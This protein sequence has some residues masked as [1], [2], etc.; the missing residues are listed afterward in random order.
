VAKPHLW[1]KF[2]EESIRLYSLV[3]Q[4]GRMVSRNTEILG[5]PMNKGDMVWLGLAQANRDPRKFADPDA[6][7]MERADLNHHLGFGAGVHR[8]IGMHLA[9]AELV[10]ALRAW[11]AVI[12]E[13]RLAEG[14]VITERGGQLRLQTLPLVWD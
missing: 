13:Y 1:P 4:D 6:F 12:P 11:H 3:I 14:A 7:D 5:C 8:C 2:I 10:I 9:R